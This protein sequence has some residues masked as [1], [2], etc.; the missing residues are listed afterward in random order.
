MR[1]GRNGL[2]VD[3]TAIRPGCLPRSPQGTSPTRHPGWISETASRRQSGCEAA[4]DERCIQ[5]QAKDGSDHPF[6]Y[7]S[8]S[9]ASQWF[10]LFSR[11]LVGSNPSYPGPP[12]LAGGHNLSAVWTRDGRYP[13]PGLRSLECRQTMRAQARCGQSDQLIVWLRG[14]S[15]QRG[16]TR[17]CVCS[18]G[19]HY[20]CWP[21]D[22]V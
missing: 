16:G 20:G 1:R 11:F 12:S 8:V 2:K 4:V 3:R 18:R 14:D 6:H 17:R 19:G 7:S 9:I 15:P 10:P 5:H 13:L 21:C 22:A